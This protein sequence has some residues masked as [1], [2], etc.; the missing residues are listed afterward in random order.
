MEDR[1]AEAV[2]DTKLRTPNGALWLLVDGNGGRGMHAATCSRLVVIGE[3]AEKEGQ[4]E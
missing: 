3:A 2:E 4:R 1:N